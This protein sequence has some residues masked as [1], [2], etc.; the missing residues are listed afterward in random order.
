MINLLMFDLD[1]T[2]F[3]TAKGIA[4]AFNR[5]M[6]ERDEAPVDENLITSHIGTGLRDL[7][8]KV[9]AALA[10]RLGDIDQLEKDFLR[11]YT[12]NF[13]AESIIYPGVIEFLDLWPHHVAIVSNKSEFFVRELVMNT[14]LRRFNWRKIVGGNTFST[15]KPHPQPLL[16]VIREVQTLPQNGLMIGDGLPDILAA[17][18][19]GVKSVAVEFGYTPI[20]ELI[21]SGAHAAISHYKEL[22]KVIEAF[23]SV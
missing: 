6:A 1:G 22:P 7:M 13:L 20:S 15:K 21:R 19:A 16:E 17:E 12:Q 3:D 14:E 4:N 2:L 23:S 8:T 5:L 10:H 9:D 18:R 11:H